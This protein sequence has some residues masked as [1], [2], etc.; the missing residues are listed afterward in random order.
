MKY[1]IEAKTIDYKDP[2][3]LSVSKRDI[4]AVESYQ[5]DDTI[6]NFS[7]ADIDREIESAGKLLRV[8]LTARRA[9]LN[10]Y[11]TSGKRVEE[12]PHE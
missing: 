2:K 10:G 6:K 7:D 12:L 1:I 8:V 4:T 9:H 5:L 11:P 3:D